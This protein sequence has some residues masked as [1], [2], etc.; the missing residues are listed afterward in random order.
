VKHLLKLL[1]LAAAIGF[2][3]TL[4]VCLL[5]SITADDSTP[6]AFAAV[7]RAIALAAQDIALPSLVLLALTGM[8]LMVKQPALVEARWVWAK[9]ALGLLVAGIAL[10]VVIPAATR[11]AALA[12]LALEGS[13]VL[14]PLTSALRA[15]WIGAVA[16]LVLSLAAIAL[17]VWRP[18]LGRP[19][20][21]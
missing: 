5:L 16:A 10:L 11:A 9:A 17:A 14:G 13:P 19:A 20:S 12:Q 6:T 3:G 2:V 18:R 1:H 15:E 7:R 21:E 4:A 8:L